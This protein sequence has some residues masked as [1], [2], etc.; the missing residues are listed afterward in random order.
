MS[1]MQPDSIGKSYVKEAIRASHAIRH[2]EDRI[3]KGVT[4]SGHEDYVAA[5][6]DDLIT[7]ALGIARHIVPVAEVVKAAK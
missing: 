5:Q 7:A 1:H 2:G 4:V 6:T 3:F